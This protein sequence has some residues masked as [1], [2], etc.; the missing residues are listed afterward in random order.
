MDGFGDAVWLLWLVGVVVGC[1]DDG[2]LEGVAR[3]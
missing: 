3:V 1:G 2:V